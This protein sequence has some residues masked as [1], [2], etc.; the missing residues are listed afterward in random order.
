MSYRYEDGRFTHLRPDTPPPLPM[1]K[2]SR[3]DTLSEVP[4]ATNRG[5]D[6]IAVY[7]LD[8]K[9]GMGARSGDRQ[10]GSFLP[11]GKMCRGQ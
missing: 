4:F 2:Q 3:R 10:Y 9:G 6:S 5:F 1:S 7:R 11:G 8:G